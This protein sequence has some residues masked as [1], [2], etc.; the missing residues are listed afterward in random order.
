MSPL[1][2]SSPAINACG[3]V[4][5][6]RAFRSGQHSLTSFDCL[7]R[8]AKQCRGKGAPTRT[9]RVLQRQRRFRAASARPRRHIPRARPVRGCGRGRAAGV[10]RPAPAHLCGLAGRRC[11]GWGSRCG[12]TRPKAQRTAF[13]AAPRLNPHATAVGHAPSLAPLTMTA[14]PH[15]ATRRRAAHGAALRRQRAALRR[16]HQQ[17]PGGAVRPALAAAAHGQGPHVRQQDRGHQ[18]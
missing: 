13:D 6:P 11:G 10:L 2:S 14:G 1:P 3:E 4:A 17:R 5:V 8:T 16:G 15:A 7:P 12:S 18:G 9:R